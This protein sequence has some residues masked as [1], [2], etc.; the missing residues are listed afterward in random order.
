M[1]GKGRETAFGQ[2][3]QRS[4]S[5]ELGIYWKTKSSPVAGAMALAMAVRSSALKARLE[6]KAAGRPHKMMRKLYTRSPGRNR[7]DLGDVPK[8]SHVRLP[9]GCVI[10][11]P[12][13]PVCPGS[14]AVF[15]NRP[16][17]RRQAR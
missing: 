5:R 17:R 10:R 2:F 3:G 9:S 14:P 15:L 11:E 4:V 7:S 6:Q 16:V 13:C 8:N 1:I 12:V